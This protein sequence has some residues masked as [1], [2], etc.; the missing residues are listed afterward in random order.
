VL[1]VI[2]HEDERFHKEPGQLFDQLVRRRERVE[3]FGRA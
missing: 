1:C 2:D 3:A